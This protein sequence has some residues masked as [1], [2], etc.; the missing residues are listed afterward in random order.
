M[1]L[2]EGIELSTSPFIHTTRFGP[3]VSVRGASAFVRWTIP[4]SSVIDLKIEDP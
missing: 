2:P 4:S 3:P 1:V